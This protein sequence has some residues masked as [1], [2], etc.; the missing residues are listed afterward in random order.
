MY[1]YRKIKLRSFERGALFKKGEFVRMLP[2]HDTW[3][4]DPARNTRV[5]VLSTRSPWVQSAELDVMIK[6]DAFGDEAQVIQLSDHERALVWIDNRFARILTPGQYV[7][8]SCFREVRVEI[9]RCDSVRFEHRDLN[10]ILE[11]GNAS[12]VL[13]TFVVPEG[14]TGL[15]YLAG[16]LTEELAPGRYAFW[17]GIV[18]V[19]MFTVEL[20]ESVLDLAGQE[21]MT[22]DKVTLRLNALVTFRVADAR[23]AVSSVADFNQALYRECQLGLR[24]LVGTISLD[25]LLARKAEMSKE[26]ERAIGE[27]AAGMGLTLVTLGIKDIILPGEMKELL[28]RVTEAKKAAEASVITRREETAAMRSQLNTA[29]LMESNPTLLRLRELETLERVVAGSNLSVVVGEKGLTDNV[30]KLV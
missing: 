13:E 24:A 29:K 10:A 2:G 22:E 4:F 7:I 11:R 3:V 9:V 15:I 30:L 16:E 1:P 17:K 19:R 27:K 21:L 23:K 18:P 25:E 14:Q 28:N 5:E 6:A 26:L 8:W 20:R 12:S